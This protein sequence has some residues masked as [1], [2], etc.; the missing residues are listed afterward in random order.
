M[1][2]SELERRLGRAGRD[3]AGVTTYE[4]TATRTR[5]GGP[6]DAWSKLR[7][8]YQRDRVTALYALVIY[9]Q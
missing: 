5:K 8:R 2:R 6:R 3:S 4:A 1:T 9:T 7:V